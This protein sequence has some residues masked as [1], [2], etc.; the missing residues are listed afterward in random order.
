MVFPSKWPIAGIP[1]PLRSRRDGTVWTRRSWMPA[2]SSGE[3]A[4]NGCSMSNLR[5]SQPTAKE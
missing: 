1:H 5:M 2:A 3:F 4:E